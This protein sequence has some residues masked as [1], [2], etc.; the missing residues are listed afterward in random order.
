[1]LLYIHLSI[2]ASI[3][4]SIHHLSIYL[5]IYIHQVKTAISKLDLFDVFLFGFELMWHINLS[6]I[7]ILNY[8]FCTFAFKTNIKKVR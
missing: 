5:S 7:F 4:L 8:E 2:Y 1:M 3:Y 6:N